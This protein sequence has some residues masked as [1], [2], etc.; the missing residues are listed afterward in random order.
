MFGQGKMTIAFLDS[1]SDSFSRIFV[2]LYNFCML[3]G[4]LVN[5]KLILLTFATSWLHKIV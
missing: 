2:Y 4:R 5:F 3:S 1:Y